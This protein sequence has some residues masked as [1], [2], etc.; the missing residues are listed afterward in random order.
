MTTPSDLKKGGRGA[1]FFEAV[2]DRY[3]LKPDEAE[4]LAEIARMLDL[5][6]ALREAAKAGPMITDGRGNLVVHPAIVEARQVRE[7]MRKSLHALGLPNDP[8]G[9]GDAGEDGEDE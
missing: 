8:E 2:A 9:D 3:E 1:T 7:A 6:D 4:L 5:L